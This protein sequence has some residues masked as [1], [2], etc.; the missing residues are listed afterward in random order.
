MQR[1]TLRLFNAV[2]TSYQPSSKTLQTAVLERTIKHGYILD[3]TIQPDEE[4]LQT[5]ESVVGISGEKANSAFH[6]SWEVVQDSSLEL[7]IVQQIAHYITTYGFDSLGIYRQDAVYI[8]AEVLELP[9]IQDNIPLVVIHGLD[10]QDILDRIITLGSGIALAPETLA[11]IMTIVT[12]NAYDSAFVT[13]IGNRELKILLYDLYG[14]VPTEPVEY[15]RYLIYRLTGESLLIKNNDLI[16]K[17]KKADGK[18]LDRLLTDV[19]ADL[20][21]IFLRF[22]PLFLAL[23]SISS[24]KTFFNRL[25]KKADKFHQPL[26][27]DYLNSITAQIKH[28]S[29][30]F[31]ILEQKLLK[32]TIF[33][34]IRLAYAL[35]QRLS[36][37]DSIIYRVRNGRGWVTAFEWADH[38]TNMTQ[39]ALDLVLTALG[40]VLKL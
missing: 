31:A 3:P 23:K 25:R 14:L 24:N 38:L 35:K 27:E 21:A 28:N 8:P 4:I 33:R 10:S 22:K 15:L 29:L 37:G 9:A 36:D 34:K 32:A 13:K 1:A 30:D 18:V 19:P 6:K 17:L 5:I 7:L 40:R 11:D 2:Q 16:G 39:Q 20:A 12:A 26:P